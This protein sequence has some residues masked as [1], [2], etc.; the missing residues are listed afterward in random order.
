[1][2]RDWCLLVAVLILSAAAC[3]A[4]FMAG[5]LHGANL[6]MQEAAEAVWI[7]R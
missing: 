3:G 2:R 5:M 6:A 7:G 4:S 1:M